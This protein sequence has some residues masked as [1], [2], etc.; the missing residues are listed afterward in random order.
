MLKDENCS[1]LLRRVLEKEKKRIEG[2]NKG[3]KEVNGGKGEKEVNGGKGEKEVNGEK[4]EKE[5]KSENGEKETKGESKNATPSE[6]TSDIT[7]Q[8]KSYIESLFKGA[9]KKTEES[10][11]STQEPKKSPFMNT[12]NPENKKQNKEEIMVGLTPL[13]HA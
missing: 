3:E 8:M 6:P 1:P 9:E 7:E 5:V 11:S 13:T 12:L 2:G 4:G 10:T